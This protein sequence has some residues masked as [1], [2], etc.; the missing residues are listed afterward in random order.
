LF[1]KAP[2]NK[3][4]RYVHSAANGQQPN[5]P[6]ADVRDREHLLACDSDGGRE[7]GGAGE[8]AH[9]QTQEKAVCLFRFLW[10]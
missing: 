1:G 6:L 8:D 9:K 3:A 4:S 10:R 7:G 5:G 2:E